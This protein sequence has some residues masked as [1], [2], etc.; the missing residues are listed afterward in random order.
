[1]KRFIILLL[2]VLNFSSFAQSTKKRLKLGGEFYRLVRVREVLDTMLWGRESIIFDNTEKFFVAHG[3]DP[4]IGKDYTFFQENVM[5]QFLFSKR[6]ILKR[7]EYHYKHIT[8]EELSAY[9]KKIR[10]GKRRQV[11]YESGLYHMLDK[12]LDDEITQIGEKTV[13]KYLEI[14]EKW[15]RPVDLNL[16][17]NGKKVKAKDLDLQIELLTN[18]YDHRIVDI[19]DEENNQ[20]I[21]PDGYTYEQIQAIRITYKGMEFEFKPNPEIDNLPRKVKEVNS[22][23]S[24][25]S[26]EEIPEWD[27]Q[28]DETGT[29][30]SIKL[31]NVVE[32]NIVKSKP[33][34]MN[35]LKRDTIKK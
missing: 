13:P 14:I 26:F 34:M 24:Q 18:N 25:Y 9:I 15:H 6:H 1:V 19:L 21:K 29:S 4:K 32:A 7:V 23:I 17:R 33:V 8:I 30:V 20:L 2:F 35:E 16:K 28:I 10:K 11:I 27:I 22:F 12:L 31:E 3:L 5:K